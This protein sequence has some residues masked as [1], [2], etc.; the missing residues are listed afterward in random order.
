MAH[1]SARLTGFGRQLLVQRVLVLGKPVATVATEL[2]ISR[3]TAYKWLRRY[4]TEG[5]AAPAP[6]ETETE[7]ERD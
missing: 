2:G 6:S 7:P 3:T 1:R 4:R 5:E